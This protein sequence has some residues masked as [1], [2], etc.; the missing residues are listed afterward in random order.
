MCGLS[1]ADLDP[2]F[3]TIL[4]TYGSAGSSSY[5]HTQPQGRCTCFC[6]CLEHSTH[7]HT[8][9]EFAHSPCLS[10][11]S[12]V[13]CCLLTDVSLISGTFKF[14]WCTVYSTRYCLQLSKYCWGRWER[15][16]ERWRKKKWNKPERAWPRKKETEAGKE[17]ENE[18]HDKF[19]KVGIKKHAND[20]N[21]VFLAL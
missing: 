11:R 9:T 4:K 20:N 3:L 15:L 6:L 17:G 13:K 16:R 21:R 2:C 5:S 14:Q 10:S 7:T 8:H 12:Q 19:F 18:F 1:F